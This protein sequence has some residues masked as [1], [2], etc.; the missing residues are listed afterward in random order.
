MARYKSINTSLLKQFAII[1][2][3]LTFILLSVVIFWYLLKSQQEF[4]FLKHQEQHVLSIHEKAIMQEY[5]EMLSDL[6]T[7]ASL[8]IHN[9]APKSEKALEAY[10]KMLSDTYLT[11][12]KARGR[13]DQIRYISHQGQE[14]VRVN[15]NNGLPNIV[16][17][18]ELQ[19]K[20]HRYYVSDICNLQ[21]GQIYVSRMDL[22]IENHQLE[23]PYKPMIRAGMNIFDDA[24]NPQGILVLNYLGNRIFEALEYAA[25]IVDSPAKM[26]LLDQDGYWLKGLKPNQAWGFM[27]ADK[28]QVSFA[29]QEPE[30]WQSIQ[31]QS[32]GQINTPEGLYTFRTILPLKPDTFPDSWRYDFD[33]HPFAT[34]KDLNDYS[35]ILVSLI[36]KDSFSP[37][38]D[39]LLREALPFLAA[40]LIILAIFAYLLATYRQ[41]KLYF[42]NKTHFM[43]YHDELTGLYNR[44]TLYQ[45][46]TRNKILNGLNNIPYAVF[47]LDLDGFKPVN[48][49]Y[50]H[51]I[52]DEVLKVIAKRIQNSVRTSD[53]VVRLGGDE[54]AII[55]P[56]IKRSLDARHL[57]DK[58][59]EQISAPIQ[60]APHTLHLS[61]SIGIALS[62]Q[63]GENLEHLIAMADA[64]MY[65]A[66][67][68]KEDKICLA[69]R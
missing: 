53:I 37:Q 4:E 7:L 35:W 34:Q 60:V 26:M 1:F 23:I 43:A 65:Q 21:S 47:F 42:Q 51:N 38:T 39:T 45:K 63:H 41:D 67:Q 6:L 56:N 40:S 57:A 33:N 20:A 28:Q 55:T 46:S 11:V 13:Y 14:L 15:F 27:F 17:E 32:L 52:G 69:E 29:Y 22:N 68:N 30:I 19:N 8:P 50:G 2:S 62:A 16:P 59:H 24:G 58:L 3:G 44:H 49:Q 12:S 5:E 18:D 36:P 66:K 64:A 10:T 31:K 9:T 54:F 25:H 61:G 48:D